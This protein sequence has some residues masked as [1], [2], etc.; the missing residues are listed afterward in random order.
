MMRKVYKLNKGDKVALITPAGPINSAKLSKAVSIVEKLGLKPVW[1]DK[2]HKHYGYLAG[3]DQERLQELLEAYTDPQIKAVFAIRGG[4]GTLRLLDKIPY[5]LIA[6]NPK[7]LLGFSDITA[8]Q[9]AFLKKA[10]LP[11]LHVNLSSLEHEYTRKIFEQIVFQ[12]DKPVLK[13]ETDFTPKPNVIVPGQAEGLIAGGNLSLLSALCGTGYLPKFKGK[14]VFIEE[15]NEPPYKIDKM[16]TQLFLATD[17]KKAKGIVFGIFNKCNRENF[18][19]NI[20]DSL[21]LKQILLE[22]FSNFQAPVVG[23]FPLG[24]IDKMSILPIGA[25]VRLTTNPPQLEILTTIIQ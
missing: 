7:L 4:Y 12:Q 22:K 24:H 23:G 11:S 13:F 10:R 17:I 15:I 6:K 3:T 1:G 8:L 14:I 5:K 9:M 21:S 18:Y 25:K 16:L 20:Q 19:K 2:V